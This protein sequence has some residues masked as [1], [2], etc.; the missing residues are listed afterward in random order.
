M[1]SHLKEER[2]RTGSLCSNYRYI[3]LYREPWGEEERDERGSEGER[4]EREKEGKR[5]R[6]INKVIKHELSSEMT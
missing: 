2:E 6:K 5:Q 4:R 3:S 1:C